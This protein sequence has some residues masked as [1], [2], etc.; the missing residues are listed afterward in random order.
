L[1]TALAFGGVA[2]AGILLAVYFARREGRKS[3]EAEAGKKS[4]ERSKDALEI[5]EDVNRMSESD[6]DDELRDHQSD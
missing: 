3:V 1:W 6:L 5:D 2:I 4:A